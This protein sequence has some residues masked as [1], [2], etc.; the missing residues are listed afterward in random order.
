MINRTRDTVAG[1][2]DYG[3]TTRLIINQR[4]YLG[5]A[6]YMTSLYIDWHEIIV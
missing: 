1:S 5:P 6:P 4:G 2:I 3:L